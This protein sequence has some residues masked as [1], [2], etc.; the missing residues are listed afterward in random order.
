MKTP[1]PLLSRAAI[2]TLS[3]GVAACAP[4]GGA[5]RPT[6]G[7]AASAPAAWQAPLPA[8]SSAAT[9]APVPGRHG[10]WTRFDDPL[11]PPLI[12]A[13]VAAS[14]TLASAASRIEQARA[15]Q[16]AAAAGLMPQVDAAASLARGRSDPAAPVASLGTAGVRAAWEIDLFGAAGAARDAAS[17]RLAA[18]EAAA[19]AARVA[20]AAE[21]GTLYTALRACE[22]QVANA[23]ADADS[24][25]AT[26]RVTEDGARAGLIAPATAAL[27]RASAAQARAQLTAQRSA[28]DSQ[29]KAL[30]ALTA[31]PEAALRETLATRRGLVPTAPSVVPASVPASALAQ[32][33][34]LHEAAR[35]V[36]AAAADERSAQARQLPRIA[37]AGSVGAASLRTGGVSL[38]GTTWSIGPLQVTLPVFDAGT[39]AAQVTAARA[40]YDEAV[41]AYAARLRQAVREVEDALLALASTAA[42]EADA[43]VAVEGF[44][45]SFRATDARF[46]GG[47]ASAFE[48]EDARRSAVAAASALVELRRERTTAWINLYRALGGDPDGAPAPAAAAPGR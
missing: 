17:A 18:S 24:R 14:P 35:Q 27:S 39:R 25:T 6:P 37:L 8:E 2:A 12:E 47:L 10:W 42:R 44:E 32:R 46:K 5:S 9:S 13:A 45:A 31:R 3:L 1:C 26:A 29:V 43:R 41:A 16:V 15:A 40:A 28:C 38:D 36:E 48:L 23:Q 30:V 11:L 34:D 33:A 21:V 19:A 22:A 20:L 7:V 4:L